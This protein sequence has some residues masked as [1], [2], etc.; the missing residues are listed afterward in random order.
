MKKLTLLCVT[1]C[2][3]F[4]LRASAADFTEKWVYI[5][6]NLA[7]DENVTN[8]IALLRQAKRDGCTHVL[9]ADSK[10]GFLARCSRSTSGT[11][12]SC[13]TPPKRSVLR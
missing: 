5:S 7:V 12:A 11:P 1:L 3:A 9:L 4:A 10:F 8:T 2:L 13:A 6:T